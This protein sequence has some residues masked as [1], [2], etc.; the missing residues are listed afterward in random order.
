MR[1]GDGL[2]RQRRRTARSAS[3]LRSTFSLVL[4]TMPCDRRPVRRRRQVVDAPRRAAAGRRGSSST[5]RRGSASACRP[6]CPCAG[7]CGASPRRPACLRGSAR[8]AGRRSVRGRLEQVLALLL[9]LVLVRRGDVHQAVLDVRLV[10][11][12]LLRMNFIWTRSMTPSN[13]PDW[14]AGHG[15]DGRARCRAS[16]SS[17]RCSRRSRRPCGRA[18]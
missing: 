3:G 15:A 11:R 17:A 18:C 8:A 9:G 2:E 1:L 14:P 12:V 4:G 5:S 7:P 6:A 16:P 13:S 10:G